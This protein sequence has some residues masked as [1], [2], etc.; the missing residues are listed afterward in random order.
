MLS[1]VVKQFK[2]L[3]HFN[4]AIFDQA[5]V[6]GSNFLYG[7][8]L[9]R[10]LGVEGFG[11]FS[12]VWVAILFVNNI[13]MAYIIS[14]MMTFAPKKVGV[15]RAVYG[16]YAF[17]HAVFFAIIS[18]L[19]LFSFVKASSIFFSEW[20]AD[21]YAY[22]IL[23]VSFS[24]QLQEYLRRYLYIKGK[25]AAVCLID[26]VR[27][28]G[29]VGLLFVLSIYLEVSSQDALWIIVITSTIS[30]VFSIS[31]CSLSLRGLCWKR[32]YFVL[33][34]HRHLKFSK[35][36][37][38][39]SLLQW[40]AGNIFVIAAAALFGAAAAGMIKAVMN[41]VGILHILF[42]AL[43]NIITPRASYIYTSNGIIA[44]KNYLIK[45]GVYGGAGTLCIGLIITMN[46]ELIIE[47]VYQ[48]EYVEGASLL[49]WLC[50]VYLMM[51]F[52]FIFRI[53]LRT[54]EAVS[55]IFWTYVASSLV[56]FIIAEPL[57]KAT[58]IDG[59]GIGGVIVQTVSLTILGVMLNYKAKYTKGSRM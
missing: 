43:E 46:A 56:S 19:L 12:L 24:T 37:I 15:I 33:I 53:A 3:S 30:F 26:L 2:N 13:Q 16:Q 50:L 9:A 54:I 31:S 20:Q 7:I 45:W 10:I 48:G 59:V 18:S 29:Q 32:K 35:W 52:G 39:S 44:L 58:G 40:F 49:R 27:Y 1:S 36:L 14:P 51:Y 42:H 11:Y 5:I 38:G 8:L 28:G 34:F 23:F 6:S 17:I 55:P 4:W 41:I 21:I 22:A 47:F 25:H 57:I